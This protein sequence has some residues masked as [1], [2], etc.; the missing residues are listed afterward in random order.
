M[1]FAEVFCPRVLILEVKVESANLVLRFTF[2]ALD[3]LARL[4]PDSRARAEVFRFVP[5]LAVTVQDPD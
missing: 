5:A 4:P 3:I 1:E 2:N